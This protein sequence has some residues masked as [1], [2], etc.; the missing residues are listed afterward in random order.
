MS[1][2]LDS[3]LNPLLAVG[4]CTLNLRS[5]G[6][7]VSARGVTKLDC[8]SPSGEAGSP[9]WNMTVLYNINNFLYLA[10][11]E[12]S[13]SLSENYLPERSARLGETY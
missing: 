7:A 2:H 6:T 12:K 3:D 5:K 11:S 4:N 8:F 13:L 9:V 1:R 10:E